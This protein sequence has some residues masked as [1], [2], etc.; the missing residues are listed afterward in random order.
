MPITH[1]NTGPPYSQNGANGMVAVQDFY[2]VNAAA[3]PVS[4]PQR[5]AS[6]AAQ[7]GGPKPTAG[8]AAYSWVTAVAVLVIIR[9]LWEMSE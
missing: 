2:G 3:A 8:G 5:V 7:V 4:G 9:I 6:D 1:I